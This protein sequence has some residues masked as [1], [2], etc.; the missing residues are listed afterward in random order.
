MLVAVAGNTTASVDDG[1]PGVNM[2][3]KDADRDGD[4]EIGSKL[5]EPT[6]SGEALSSAL[7]LAALVAL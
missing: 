1:G 6:S 5:E 4:P 2:E 3:D 7:L